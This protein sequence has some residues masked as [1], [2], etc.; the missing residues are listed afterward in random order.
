MFLQSTYAFFPREKQ[1]TQVPLLVIFVQPVN[2]M[3]L[4]TPCASIF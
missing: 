2:H 3:Y 1:A 4:P